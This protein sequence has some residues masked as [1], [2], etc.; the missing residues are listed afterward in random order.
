VR[1][2]EHRRTA[3]TA[4]HELADDVA[5]APVEPGVRLIEQPQARRR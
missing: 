3:A 5:T 1:G 4:S 2:D